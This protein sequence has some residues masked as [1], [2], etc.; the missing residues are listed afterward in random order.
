[1]IHYGK[2]GTQTDLKE[3]DIKIAEKIKLPNGNTFNEVEF[4]GLVKLSKESVNK[5]LSNKRS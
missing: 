2:T 4:T 3:E 5:I 1:M